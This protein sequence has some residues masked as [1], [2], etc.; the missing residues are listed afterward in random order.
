MVKT[1]TMHYSWE[2]H[3]RQNRKGLKV[4]ISMVFSIGGRPVW[5]ENKGQGEEG[6]ESGE[7]G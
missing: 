7:G 2:E 5:L 6:V 3:S 1:S 4:G